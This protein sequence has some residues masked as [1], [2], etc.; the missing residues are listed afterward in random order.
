MDQHIFA[1]PDA[2]FDEAGGKRADALVKFT[3][4]PAPRWSLE[5]R[6]DQEWM[7]AA[8]L[9]AHPQQPWHVEPCEWSDNAWR[10]L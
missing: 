10:C 9:G 6:P 7:V 3:V 5:R 2:A 8:A 1:G 4:G